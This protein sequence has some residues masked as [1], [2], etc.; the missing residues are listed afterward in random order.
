MKANRSWTRTA[1]GG[2]GLAA[3]AVPV[4]L[5]TDDDNVTTLAAPKAAAVLPLRGVALFYTGPTATLDVTLHLWE[6]T[7][8]AFLRVSALTTLTAN[9]ITRIVLPAALQADVA[10]AWQTMHV[11]VTIDGDAGATDGDHVFYLWGDLGP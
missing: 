10:A 1:A 2:T 6:E 9:V 7:A 3:D 8:A 4:A 11:L 5:D